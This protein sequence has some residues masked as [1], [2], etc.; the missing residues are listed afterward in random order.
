MEPVRVLQ[1]IG[2]MDRAGAE[3]VIMNLFR[4]MDPSKVVFDFMVHEQRECDYDA[5]IEKLG[6]HIYRIPR[7]TVANAPMYKRACR[8]VFA[9]HPEIQVVHGHIGSSSYLYLDEAHKAGCATVVHSHRE[10]GSQSLRVR[11]YQL[12]V[13]PARGVADRFLACSKEAGIDR[14]GRDVVEGPRFGLMNNGIEV[15]RFACD[16][17]TH[18]AMKRKLG[19]GDVP[20]VGNVARL[21]P[22]K[23]Q[24]FL[25]EVFA[26]I[27]K[28]MPDARLVLLGRG[29]SEDELRQRVEEMGIAENVEFLGIRDNVDEYMKAFDAF[30]FPSIVEGFPMAM[31][32]AQAAGAPAFYATTVPE[33]VKLAGATRRLPLESGAAAW[34]EEVV[35]AMANPPERMQ[36][37]R[38]VIANGYEIDDVAAGMERFYLELAAKSPRGMGLL[39]GHNARS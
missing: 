13:L 22:E 23:N 9:Q 29:P 38:D 4:R 5:E 19:Y 18:L 15:A 39:E 3:T 32:E 33:C 20:L 24:P 2:A 31:V 21:T 36:G 27:L 30:V 11:L 26:E 37:A 17:E 6:G 14:F 10:N 28:K 7:F 35:A 16:D 34:A 1:V 25:F 12:L 8:D